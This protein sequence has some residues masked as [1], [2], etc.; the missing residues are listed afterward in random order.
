M[1]YHHCDTCFR[2]SF[3]S[4]VYN[5][6]SPCLIDTNEKTRSRSRAELIRSIIFKRSR[7]IS[8]VNRAAWVKE[9]KKRRN[10]RCKFVLTRSIKSPFFLSPLLYFSLFLF[11]DTYEYI[12]SQQEEFIIIIIIIIENPLVA[13]GLVNQDQEQDSDSTQVQYYNRNSF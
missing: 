12:T 9:K 10:V 4:R 3:I 8:Y 13:T 6:F 2:C 5:V 7:D 1:L 11:Q